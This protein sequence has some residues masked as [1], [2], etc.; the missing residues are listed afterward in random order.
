[1]LGKSWNPTRG[2]TGRPLVV[3]ITIASSCGFLLFGYDNGVF[4]GISVC[5]W[6]LKTFNHPK[7]GL[8]G[9]ISAMYN[10]GGFLGS[11]ATF[12][13][14]DMFGRRRTILIGLMVTAVGAITQCVATNLGELI[15]GR[16]ICGIG[17]GAMTSTV[18]IWQAETVPARTHGR[19][20]TLQLLCGAALG[21]FFAQW[22]NYRFHNSTKRASFIFPVAFQLIFITISGS[23]VLFLPESPRWLVKKDRTSEALGILILLEGRSGADDRLAQ[24]LVAH[25][26]ERGI[27]GNPYVQLF[28]MRPT[29]NFHRLCLACGIMILH[30]VNGVNSITYYFPFLLSTFIHV[31]HSTTLWVAGMTSVTSLIFA[32]IPVLT[33]DRLGRRPFLWGGAMF[34]CAMFSIIAA[35]LATAPAG[36][37][38]YG[39][40][41]VVMMFLFYGVNA[42][43]WL[44]PSWAYPAE[45][46]TL[47]SRE[48]GLALG[49]VCYWLFQ[50]LFVEVTPSAI[51]NIGWKWFMILAVFNACSAGTVFLFYPETSRLSLE[52][53]DFYFAEKYGRR[54]NVVMIEVVGN[55][56]VT[57][58]GEKRNEEGNGE[59]SV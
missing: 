20:L 53:I 48:K 14:G 32:T 42:A 10:I 2:V 36:S 3:L 35:L 39:V 8:L 26:L 29:R 4:S 56:K 15:S 33:I 27:G 40:A 52:E 45:I 55:D 31:R 51:S 34:Q 43:T 5:P 47:Q 23:L 11:F 58:A 28:S 22:I 7:S 12:F 49:N 18:G 17:V 59:A 37:Q 46:V 19:Y 9:T 38:S 6:F 24:I 21:L 54:E 50:F 1:M 25:N 30:Q 41:A 44:G 13:L 57:R 16:I